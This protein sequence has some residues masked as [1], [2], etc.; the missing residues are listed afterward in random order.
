MRINHG[1]IAFKKTAALS[2]SLFLPELPYI[3]AR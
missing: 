3:S 2:L 1:D